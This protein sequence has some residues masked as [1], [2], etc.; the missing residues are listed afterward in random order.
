[1]DED[2]EWVEDEDEIKLEDLMKDLNLEDKPELA[3]PVDEDH[4]INQ[5]ISR[6]ENIKIEK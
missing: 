5:F 4:E 2:E 3:I 6:L 1:M